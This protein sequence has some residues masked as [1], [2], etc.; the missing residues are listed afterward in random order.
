MNKI[1]SYLTV[2]VLFPEFVDVICIAKVW[3]EVS[4][5]EGKHTQQLVDGAAE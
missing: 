5:E 1:V 4:P 2:Y 3:N